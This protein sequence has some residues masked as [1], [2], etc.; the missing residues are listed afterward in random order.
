[1]IILHYESRF[2]LARG[3]VYIKSQPH[4]YA[5]GV[6]HDEALTVLG[7]RSVARLKA[8][9]GGLIF[10]ALADGVDAV[11]EG[12]QEDLAKLAEGAAVEVEIIAE[13]RAGKL[14]RARF[15][16][17]TAAEPGRASPVRSLKARLL[18]QAHDLIGD[19]PVETGCDRDAILEARSQ[20]LDPGG[21]LSKGGFLSIEPTRAL[22]ACDIDSHQGE[23]SLASTPKSVAKTCNEA[24]VSDLPRRLRL[25]G[26][27][28]LVVV[29]LIGKRHDF[30][31]LK[32]LLLTGFA[33]EASRII[34]API[35]KFGTLEFIR[36]WGACPFVQDSQSDGNALNM[37]FKAVE[38]TE[39]DHSRGVLIRGSARDIEQIR[40][41]LAGSLD[42]LAPMLRLD[43][44][45]GPSEVRL[46]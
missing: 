17:S 44:S 33:S 29:D 36:P 37:L 10:I 43:V 8:R 25:S 16:S 34:V 42:P 18:E 2:G 13:R 3:A 31:R 39:H 32:T 23:T 9:A 27:A 15:L 19:M 5:E 40:R 41:R 6:E 20:A 11:L 22:I 14:A 26:H 24:A 21:A 35:G 7:T 38:L 46:I 12:P 1:M 30:D 4:L 28:G 45:A